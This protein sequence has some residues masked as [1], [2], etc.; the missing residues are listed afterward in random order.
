MGLGS[1]GDATNRLLE[2]ELESKK[3]TAYP[4]SNGNFFLMQ[5]GL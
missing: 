5:S 2:V 4:P 1:F 3:V